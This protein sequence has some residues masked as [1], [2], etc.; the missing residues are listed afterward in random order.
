MNKYHVVSRLPGPGRTVTSLAPGRINPKRRKRRS[1]AQAAATRKLVAMNRRRRRGHIHRKTRRG[2]RGSGTWR[3]L[4]I[5]LLE[6]RGGTWRTVA[7]FQGTPRGIKQAKGYARKYAAFERVQ[8]R[9][10][11][12]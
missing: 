4:P 8:V 10:V 5:R 7:A 6:K 9:L 11:R 1:R 3:G 2:G 12:V